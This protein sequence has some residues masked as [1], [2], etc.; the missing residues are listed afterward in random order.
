MFETIEKGL[1]LAKAVK[2]V[3]KSLNILND[4]IPIYKEVKPTVLSAKNIFRSIVNKQIGNS[5]VDSL[6][7][8][9]KKTTDLSKNTVVYNNKP[10]FFT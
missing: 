9:A 10:T 6:N 7:K 1:T 5:S 8:D 2:G 3:S 4:L